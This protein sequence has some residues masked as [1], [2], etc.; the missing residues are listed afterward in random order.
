MRGA[1]EFTILDETEDLLVVEKPAGVLIH[2][3]K[4]GGPRTLWDDAR[5]LLA[6]EIA[7][8]GQVSIV[9]RLD[10]ETSGVVLMAKTAAAAREM[11]MAMAAGRVRKEYLALVFGW[12]KRDR[13]EVDAPL[14]RLG[15]VAESAIWLK[16]GVDPG[17]AEAKTAFEVLERRER[18]ASKGGGRYSL[19]RA[20]PKT[21]RTH[22]IRVHLAHAG[23]PVVGDKIYGPDEQWY[24]RFIEEGWT[25][26]M[27]EA[28]WL[29]QHALHSAALAVD[30]REWRSRASGLM[31]GVNVT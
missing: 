30:G 28:L 14:R 6:Y 7:N 27:Q 21:G 24:L 9:N 18:L 20:L 29:P 10:R 5:D 25:K 22:Q 4:P 31:P 23:Y 19:V 15:E 17:G 13:F 26:A 8:G 11:T 1:L 12:P 3:T 16:R 2:P